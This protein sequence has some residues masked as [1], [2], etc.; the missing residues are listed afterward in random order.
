MGKTIERKLDISILFPSYKFKLAKRGQRMCLRQVSKRFRCA[1]LP[2]KVGQY[3]LACRGQG[4]GYSSESASPWRRRTCRLTGISPQKCPQRAFRSKGGE[5]APNMH[6]NF[7]YVLSL[8]SDR[9]LFGKTSHLVIVYSTRHWRGG[10]PDQTPR[11][12][13]QIFGSPLL[14]CNNVSS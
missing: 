4:L 14:G 8:S 12:T 5:L 7:Q 2:P 10:F 6:R 9:T 1:E 13:R 11:A 3:Q